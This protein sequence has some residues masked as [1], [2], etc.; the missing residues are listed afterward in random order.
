MNQKRNS[1]VAVMPVQGNHTEP[2]PLP[3]GEALTFRSV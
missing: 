1:A 3:E 2:L